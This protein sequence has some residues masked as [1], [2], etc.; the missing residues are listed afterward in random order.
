[1]SEELLYEKFMPLEYEEVFDSNTAFLR[2]VDIQD[3]LTELN[4][5]VV[6]AQGTPNYDRAVAVL[7][8]E[9]DRVINIQNQYILSYYDLKEAEEAELRWGE[10][11]EEYNVASQ[12]WVFMKNLGWN[13]YV[14]AGV[15]GN[16]MNEAGGN[17]LNIQP[18]VYNNTGYYYGI[19]QWNKGGYGRIF[20]KELDAQLNLLAETVEYE[21]NTYGFVYQSGFTYEDFI[22]LEDAE[23][24]AI[25]FAKCYERCS[26]A[27][28]SV[29]KSNA[30]EAYEYFTS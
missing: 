29:R 19:C 16:M 13:D 24:A 6:M 26:S 5:L 7:Q 2:I 25:A 28:Y 27:S 17:T 20:G 21:L 8:P 23:A 9:I 3:Y 11:F 1:M 14:C 18:K 30:L 4:N 15:I 22:A 10:R 12:I